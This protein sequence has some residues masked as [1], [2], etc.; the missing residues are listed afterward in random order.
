VADCEGPTYTRAVVEPVPIGS[1]V[2]GYRIQGLVSSSPTGATYRA[3]HRAGDTVA[4]ELVAPELATIP[5]YRDRLEHAQRQAVSLNHPAIAPMADIGEVDGFLFVATEWIEGMD[6]AALI[7]QVGSLSFLRAAGIALQAAEALDAAHA[8]G[9]LH[10]ALEPRRILITHDDGADRVLLSG[11]VSTDALSAG[12]GGDVSDAWVGPP[13]AAYAAPEQIRLER[14]GPT[15]DVYGLGCV[16]YEAASGLP[17]FPRDDTEA[18]LEAHLR[19]P[20]PAPSQRLLELPTEFD[21]VVWRALAKDPDQRYPS[22]GDLAKAALWAGGV[23]PPPNADREPGKAGVISAW[24]RSL[25]A[26]AHL[27]SPSGAE[28]QPAEDSDATE[29]AGDPISAEAGGGDTLV[30]SKPSTE[31]ADEATEE[32]RPPREPVV[33]QA[34]GASQGKRR[35]RV[36]HRARIAAG[37]VALAAVVGTAVLLATSGSDDGDSEPAPRA[38]NPPQSAR[39]DTAATPTGRWPRR[40]GYTVVVG[41]ADGG[42]RGR[43][44]ALAEEA[45]R[46]GFKAGVLSSGAYSSLEPGKLVTF[47]G[48]HDSAA[49]ARREAAAVR[50]SG[51]ASAP[52][53]RF[54]N[55]GS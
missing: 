4:L 41:V 55:G 22:A 50:E 33:L 40:D 48:I 24:Q 7:Q 47:V 43:A 9:L 30:T 5:G 20:A 32:S 36:G 6:L 29:P 18:T 53:V 2:G 37:V 11:F 25:A 17:P 39:P 27:W 15:T 14:L 49:A 28:A 35:R 34:A 51:L 23:V 38:S 31:V 10:T 54:V 26:G 8:S 44:D 13:P 16:L 42:D 21:D 46:E 52:Y 19:D 1:Q 45:R 12:G 3:V